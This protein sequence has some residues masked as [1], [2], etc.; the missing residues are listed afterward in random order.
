MPEIDKWSQ[1]NYLVSTKLLHR[2]YI[3]YRKIHAMDLGEGSKHVKYLFQTE[4]AY[5]MLETVLSICK[6]LLHPSRL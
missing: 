1:Y 5:L 2:I 6:V 4:C 3:G